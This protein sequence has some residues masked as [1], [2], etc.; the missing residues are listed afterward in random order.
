MTLEPDTRSNYVFVSDYE[1]LLDPFNN[2]K[3]TTTMLAALAARTHEIGILKSLGFRPVSIFLS[4][5]FESLLLGLVGGVVGCLMT[6]PINGVETGTMNFQTFTEVAFAFRVTPRVLAT[7]VLFA[8]VLGLLGGAWP[9]WRAARMT[10]VE[11][12]R[13][14]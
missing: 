9:A 14:R 10:P 11:A 1:Q 3:T 2:R 13:R 5:L 8:V 12:W 7:A 4:F 6:L